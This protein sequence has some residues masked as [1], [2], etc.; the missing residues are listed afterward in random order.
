MHALIETAKLN[1]IDPRAWLVDVLARL[2]GYSMSR[3]RKLLPWNW[4]RP[5]PV[6]AATLPLSLTSLRQP[7]SA[8]AFTECVPWH[9]S[10]AAFA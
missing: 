4:Q 8:A 7:N 1:G 3:I 6:S 9:Q 10:R 2:P 5:A